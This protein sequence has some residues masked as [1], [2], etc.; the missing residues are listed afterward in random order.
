MLLGR[1]FRRPSH[2]PETGAGARLTFFGGKGGVGKTTCAS[3]YSLALAGAGQ[4]VLLISTDPAHSLG[5]LWQQPLAASP[6]QVADGVE[7]LEIDPTA[8]LHRYMKEVRENLAD[9]ASPELRDAALRQADLAASSPGAEESAL[10]DELVRL[11][12]EGSGTHDHLVF[13]TAP[14]GHTL[15]LLQLPEAMRTWTDALLTQR[16]DAMDTSA[17]VQGRERNPEDRAARILARRRDRYTAMRDMLLD[18]NRTQFIPVLNPDRLSLEETRRMAS[19]LDEVGVGV[20][21][22]VVNRV[23]PETADG[24]FAARRRESERAHLAAIT[25]AFPNLEQIHVPLATNDVS[26][27]RGLTSVSEVLAALQPARG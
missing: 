27:E 12:L 22:L 11:T 16:H 1:L 8:A 14:T 4:R 7:A 10:L 5:D 24:D 23:L 19:T 9:L 13:D 25:E 21:T 2:N 3:A 6:T 20:R 18:H 17:A 15:Q 26:R